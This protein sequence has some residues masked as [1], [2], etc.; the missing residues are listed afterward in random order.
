MCAYKTD[1]FDNRLPRFSQILDTYSTS[2]CGINYL[3]YSAKDGHL[4]HL[5][6]IFGLMYTQKD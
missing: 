5:K 3:Y 4:G 6:S 1:N 2:H